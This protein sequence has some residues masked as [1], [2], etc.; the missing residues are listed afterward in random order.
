MNSTADS[1]STKRPRLVEIRRY[2]PE[3]FERV[4]ALTIEGFVGVSIDY[5]IE[6]QWP[7]TTQ[8]SWGDRKF[9]DVAADLQTH[10][11]GC[12]VAEADGAVLGFVT[13]VLSQAKLQGS[14][15]DLVVDRD[16]RDQGIGRLLLTRA[17]DHFRRQGM[18]IARIETL[19][20]NAVGAHLYPRLGFRLITTQ[21]HYALKLDEY[22]GPAT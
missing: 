2:L 21:N 3:D 4:K 16:A 18:R 7:G 17:L 15:R 22:D 6:Q 10:A 11:D 8:G 20:H 14:I 19:S 9:L 12:F 5:L 1:A 13:T